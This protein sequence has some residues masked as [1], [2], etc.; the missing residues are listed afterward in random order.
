MRPCLDQSLVLE[1]VESLETEEQF[2][3]RNEG[4]LA[5]EENDKG[6]ESRPEAAATLKRYSYV[7]R[8]SGCKVWEGC[9]YHVTTMSLPCTLFC[10]EWMA[11]DECCVAGF[12]SVGDRTHSTQAKWNPTKK[13]YNLGKMIVNSVKRYKHRPRRRHCDYLDSTRCL[14]TKWACE[15]KDKCRSDIVE[16]HVKAWDKAQTTHTCVHP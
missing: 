11:E 12:F 16:W 4:D 9:G 13:Q 7:N 5:G 14:W 2:G 8:Y 10:C 15:W 6:D 1:A 3:G